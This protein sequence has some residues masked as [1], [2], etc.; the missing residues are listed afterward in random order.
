MKTWLCFRVLPWLALAGGM[1]LAFYSDAVRAN[2]I[3]R[4]TGNVVA[5]VG[6]AMLV[7]GMGGM[8]FSLL[9]FRT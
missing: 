4:E 6:S 9:S 5:T 2:V 3:T 1:L 7:F 8:L